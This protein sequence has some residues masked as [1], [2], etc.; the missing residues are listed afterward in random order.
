MLCRGAELGVTE[1]FVAMP[2]SDHASRISEDSQLVESNCAKIMV[3]KKF[4]DEC[5]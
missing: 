3:D 5:N 2:P 1:P 4:D